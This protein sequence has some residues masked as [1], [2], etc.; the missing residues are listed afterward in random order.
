V[1]PARHPAVTGLPVASARKRRRPLRLLL[2]RDGLFY[3]IAIRLLVM[4]V[5]FVIVNLM[6][7]VW[8]YA[9][10]PDQLDQDLLTL[11]AQRIVDTLRRA[12]AE[13]DELRPPGGPDTRHAFIVY[14]PGG[15]VVARHAEGDLDPEAGSPPPYRQTG[16]LREMRGERFLLT[17]SRKVM[18]GADAYWIRLA[19][20][21]EG[22]RPFLP[23]VGNEI[24]QHVLIPLVPLTILLLLFNFLVV[25]RTLEPLNSAVRDADALDPAVITRRLGEPQSPW[26]VRALVRAV[27]RA[28]D[29]L[30]RAIRALQEFAGDA[31]HELRTP[32][33]IMTLT[34]GRLPEGEEKRKLQQDTAGM[35]RLVNQMLDMAYANALEIDEG[36]RADLTAISERVISQLTPLAIERGREIRFENAGSVVIRGHS[37]AIARALRNV[38]ENALVHTPA[39]S[40][41]VVTS[42]PGAEYTVRDHG[43]GIRMADRARIFQRFRQAER[44]KSGGT[45]LGLGIVLA[46]VRAHGGRVEIEDAPGGGCMFRMVFVGDAVSQLVLPPF[47]AVHGR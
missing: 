9:N 17:G 42:G 1:P 18:V 27:N 47:F 11:E 24:V 8:L 35:A 31:A 4:A 45:G 20:V 41:V 37:E 38:V 14:G 32:L 30:E 36:A 12:P 23:A 25:R 22:F 2:P 40:A 16:T 10:E 43:P 3:Q 44:R 19:V 5:L 39:G 26:E 6:I 7:V 29:R 46:I 28:L 21:G 13:L 15:R 33:S 34:A